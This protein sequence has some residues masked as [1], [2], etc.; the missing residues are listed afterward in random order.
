MDFVDSKKLALLIIFGKL[1]KISA[2]NW[3]EGF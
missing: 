1:S 3:F 2:G